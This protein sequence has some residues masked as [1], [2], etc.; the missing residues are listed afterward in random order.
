MICVTHLPQIAA[1]ADHEYLVRKQTDGERTRTF[2][3]ELDRK[4]RI[5][6][7]GRMISGANGL[8]PQAESY[9]ENMIASAEDKRR[10]ETRCTG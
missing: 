4:G 3:T 1:A 9:A 7:I 8:D 5:A 10:T 2:V 6:E